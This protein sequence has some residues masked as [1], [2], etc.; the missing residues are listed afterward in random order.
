MFMK[1]IKTKKYIIATIAIILLIFS[2]RICC[3]MKREKVKKEADIAEQQ[4]IENADI[5]AR[6][7]EK[8]IDNMKQ[9]GYSSEFIE[10]KKFYIENNGV[11]YYFLI[12]DSGVVFDS[13]EFFVEE[14]NVAVKEGTI[15]ITI[16]D[17][18][19]GTV[20]TFYHDTRVKV[21]SDGTEEKNYSTGN[22][23]SNKEFDKSSLVINS[24]V[25]DAEQKALE[26]YDTIM[27]YTSVDK[28]KEQYNQALA[29]CN[30]LN[31]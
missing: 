24:F 5:E 16:T 29:I 1:V 28:L 14:E 7:K 18:R 11:K 13:C 20:N 30:Q 23:T 26:A 19:D 10:E 4:T 21:L 8:A 22:F 15:E 17:F 6:L 3:Y 27:E 25:P 2:V 12:D 9:N 31:E